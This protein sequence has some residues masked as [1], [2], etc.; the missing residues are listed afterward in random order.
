MKIR[1]TVDI[2]HPRVSE[3]LVGLKTADRRTLFSIVEAFG[4]RRAGIVYSVS[5]PLLNS[6]EVWSA[7]V[8]RIS[9]VLE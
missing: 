1:I 4:L 5:L 7:H 2:L 3:M 9:Q 8:L 6:D